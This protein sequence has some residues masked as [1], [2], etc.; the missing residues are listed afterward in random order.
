M[1]KTIGC[2]DP[3]LADG[4]LWRLGI[5]PDNVELLL[6]SILF[7]ADGEAV[8]PGDVPGH[9]VGQVVREEHDLTQ[10]DVR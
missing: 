4:K 1:I 3:D 2:K 5:S 10:K 7:P 6:I 9:V 8:D